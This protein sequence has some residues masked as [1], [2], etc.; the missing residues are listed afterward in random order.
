MIFR[1]VVAL[2]GLTFIAS[3]VTVLLSDTCQSVVWGPSGSDRAGRFSATC[4]DAVGAGMP[5]VTAAAIAIG[6]GS[7]LLVCTVV[8]VIMRRR[9]ESEG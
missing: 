6:L 9:S 3:G 8:P 5:Q 1:V 4:V 2:G 7:V